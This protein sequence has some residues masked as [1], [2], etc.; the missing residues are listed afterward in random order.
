MI[1]LGTMHYFLGLQVLPICVGFFISQP[2]YV[3]DLL[4]RIRMVDCNTCAT[5]LQYGLNLA[6]SYQTPTINTLD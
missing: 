4:T 6:K 2:K 1:D 5:P 3:M